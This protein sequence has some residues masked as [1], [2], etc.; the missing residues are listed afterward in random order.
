MKIFEVLTISPP[1]VACSSDHAGTRGGGWILFGFL[2]TA[3]G[4]F[5]GF[6]DGNLVSMAVS[7]KEQRP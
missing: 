2:R 7:Q 3:R 4:G 1:G 6:R 5:L